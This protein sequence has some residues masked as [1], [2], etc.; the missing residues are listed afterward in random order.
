MDILE[1][2][3]LDLG[4]RIRAGE[5]SPMEAARAAVDAAKRDE[6]NAYIFVDEVGAVSYTHLDVYKRQL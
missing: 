4:Q 2:S 5:I 3:A 1:Y 6:H